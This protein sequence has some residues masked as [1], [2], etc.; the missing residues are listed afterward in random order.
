MRFTVA[1][2]ILAIVSLAISVPESNPRYTTR[3]CPSHGDPQQALQHERAT[4]ILLGQKHRDPT[5]AEALSA[6]KTFKQTV[7]VYFHVITA[8]NGDKDVKDSQ[9]ADQIKV[10]N[11]AY[12]TGGISFTVAGTERVKNDKWAELADDVDP[13]QD[14]M[15]SALRKGGPGDLNVYITGFGNDLLGYATFPMNYKNAPKDDGV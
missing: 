6:F 10:L 8:A 7:K 15:K 13:S 12:A 4:R 3:G 2:S 11:A 14:A 1:T 9:L 5:S